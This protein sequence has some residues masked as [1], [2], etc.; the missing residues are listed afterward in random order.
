MSVLRFAIALA[1]A[2]SS[3][4]P[5]GVDAQVSAPLATGGKV[6][7][8]VDSV[9]LAGYHLEITGVVQGEAAPSVWGVYWTAG[10]DPTGWAAMCQRNALLALSKPGQFLLEI[11][12]GG[13]SGTAVCKL[14]RVT[15]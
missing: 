2:I 12:W 3:V 8:T 11:K 14:T 4:L 5:R 9:S 13:S 15:P 6:F 10:G 7:A 1:I